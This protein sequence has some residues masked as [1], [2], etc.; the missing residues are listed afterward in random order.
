MELTI[1]NRHCLLPDAV[2]AHTQRRMERLEKYEPRPTEAVVQFQ[3]DGSEKSAEI[4]L[5]VRGGQHLLASATG[6]TFRSA[7]DRCA[8]RLERQLKRHRERH[9]DHQAQPITK[10][11][12][13]GEG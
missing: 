10:T 12:N 1:T 4:R 13:G 11:T 9:T 8:Q 7:L 2:R 3:E 5:S 6:T